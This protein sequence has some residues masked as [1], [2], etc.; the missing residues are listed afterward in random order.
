MFGADPLSVISAT[1]L[2]VVATQDGSTPNV[3]AGMTA[4][5]AFPGDATATIGVYLREPLRFGF[6]PRM[7]S[8]SLTA[9]CENGEMK[10][11]NY[12]MP[13]VYHYIE[14]TTKSGPQGKTIKKRVEKVYKPLDANAKGEEW[15]LTLVICLYPVAFV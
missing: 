5:F 11:F 15:W 3:D 9:T 8:I 4:T 6:I 10:I 2:E 1:P 12:V 13:S 14:V 7:P